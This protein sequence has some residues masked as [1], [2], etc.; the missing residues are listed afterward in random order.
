MKLLLRD[1]QVKPACNKMGLHPHFQQPEL[2]DLCNENGII[3][4]GYSPRRHRQERPIDQ[5]P[6]LPL[7]RHRASYAARAATGF[8]GP[9]LIVC[10]R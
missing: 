8:F 9:R 2:F 1:C 6:R 10:R 3:P 5:G 7:A 4:V